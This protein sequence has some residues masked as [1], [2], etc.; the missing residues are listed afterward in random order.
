VTGE[1]SGIATTIFLGEVGGGGGSFTDWELLE[2]REGCTY[3]VLA[4]KLEGKRPLGRS[5]LKW[6]DNI[7][8][9][10]QKVGRGAMD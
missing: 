1:H 5:R 7:K 9:D 3:R 8:M 2:E 6:E 4:G 10:L